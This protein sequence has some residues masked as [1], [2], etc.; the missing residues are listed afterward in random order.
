MNTDIRTVVFALIVCVLLVW[1]IR[2]GFK[3]GVMKEIVNILSA[4]V[5][6][7]CVVLIF[8]TI[9]S[10]IERTISML[11]VCVVGLILL[12]VLF[13]VC[14]LIFK[15]LLAISNVSVIGGIN[16]L[17]GAVL[18]IAEAGAAAYLLYRICL[19]MGIVLIRY[20]M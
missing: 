5:S 6:L 12:G 16:K 14:S 20:S 18:G 8:L 2:R 15:P 7:I 9:S 10:V 19:S 13:K 1:R 17:L 11:V 3:N 4:A